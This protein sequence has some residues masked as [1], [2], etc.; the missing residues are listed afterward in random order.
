LFCLDIKFIFSS[1]VRTNFIS[2]HAGGGIFTVFSG[3]SDGGI[4]AFGID[5]QN[6]KHGAFYQYVFTGAH[7]VQSCYFDRDGITFLR[8]Q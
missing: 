4:E 3:D 2:W 5:G 7:G 8:V 6:G 1:V